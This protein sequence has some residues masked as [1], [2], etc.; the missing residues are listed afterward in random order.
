MSSL[1]ITRIY[2]HYVSLVPQ[3]VVGRDTS[4]GIATRY[5]LDGPGIE[6]RWGRDF[7]HPF[8][9]ALRPTQPPIQWIPGLFP[10]GVKRPGHG[11]DHQPPSN[12]EVKERVKL[13]LFSPSGP[14][15]PVIG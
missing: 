3:C 15:W 1:G 12:A 14:S 5:G 7:P 10:E 8:R 11:V 9:P 13:Y 6:C 2:S 4:V